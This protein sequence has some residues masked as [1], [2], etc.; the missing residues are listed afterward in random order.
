MK[1]IRT[2]VIGP[3]KPSARK[4]KIQATDEQGSKS[5]SYVDNVPPINFA[6][7]QYAAGMHCAKRGDKGIKLTSAPLKGN[8]E[9]IHI[10]QV[11][12]WVS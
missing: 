12:T 10:E 4:I 6:D 11:N 5:F 7:H 8:T 1:I 9:W 3:V 2:K